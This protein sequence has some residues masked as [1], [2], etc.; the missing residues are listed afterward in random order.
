ML[1]GAVA[2]VTGAG[3]GLGKAEALEL[4]REGARVVVND[5]GVDLGGGGG[6]KQPADEVVAQIKQEGG[7]AIPHYG[8]VSS[9]DDARGLISFAISTYGDLNILVNNAGILRDRMIFNMSEE[10]WDAVI[11]VHLKGHFGTTR[12]ATE[13]WR[14]RAK[15]HGAQYARIINT[16]SEAFLFGSG[17]Q[18]NYAAAKAGIVALTMATA[19]SCGKYGVTANAICPRAFTRMTEGLGFLDPVELGPEKVAPLV[20]YLASKEAE[21]ISGQVFIAYGNMVAV[22]AQLAVDTRFETDGTWTAAKLSEAMGP[23]FE[24]RMPIADGFAMPPS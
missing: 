5:L 20:A 12:F 10:E 15:E 17:G 13:Y 2:I 22:M 6:G 23:F 18:P 9:F 21:R 24:K 3:S 11:R 1:D 4:A 7:E 14:D 19:Q 8:D 16:S